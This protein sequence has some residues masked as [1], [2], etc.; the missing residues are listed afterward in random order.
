VR[1]RTWRVG[2]EGFSEA[3]VRET[4]SRWEKEARSAVRDVDDE[5]RERAAHVS[6]QRLAPT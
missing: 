1:R 2:D 6:S 4:L 3:V 5:R